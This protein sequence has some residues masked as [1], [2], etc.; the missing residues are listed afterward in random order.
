MRF[1]DIIEER[2]V[3]QSFNSESYNAIVRGIDL[4]LNL[5]PLFHRAKQGLK[6]V[7]AGRG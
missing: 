7:V 4:I 2:A 1:M 6:V 3:P 5:L